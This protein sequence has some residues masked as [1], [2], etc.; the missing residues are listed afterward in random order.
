MTDTETDAAALLGQAR[1][2]HQQ[3]DQ[4][5]DALRPAD[6]AAAY[7]V[8]DAVHGYLSQAGAGPLVGHKIGCTTAVMQQYLGI[9]NP[10]AGQIFQP[11]VHSGEGTFQ[12]H[13]N[14]RIGVECEIAVW[15]TD[16]LPPRADRPYSR[17]DV[18]GAVGAC[19][20]AIEVV[21]D[22]YVDYPSLDTPT[23]I[24][25]DFFNAGAVLGP[26]RDAFDLDRLPSVTARMLID[27]VEVG[28]GVGSDV[29]AHPLDALAWLAR[30]ASDRGLTLRAGEFVLLGS[31]VQ[32]NWVTPGSVVEIFND[33]LGEAVARFT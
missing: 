2:D 23:L 14:V 8:Q 29:M 15:L 9:A 13:G 32:T 18:R 24:A 10:C 19:M 27:G 1:L 5:P 20:A 25:D 16:D 33:P 17:A 21:E 3:F 7:R 12:H 28:N 11:T 22:R 30:S 4:L 31:L 26:R 6:E